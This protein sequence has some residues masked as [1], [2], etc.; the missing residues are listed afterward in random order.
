LNQRL[1]KEGLGIADLPDPEES[2]EFSTVLIELG[3]SN[4][5]ERM[6]IRKHVKEY[7]RGLTKPKRQSSRRWTEE[8]SPPEEIVDDP[9]DWE[10]LW[11]DGGSTKVGARS[12]IQ[13]MPEGGRGSIMSGDGGS[14]MATPRLNSRRCS[15]DS[16][17]VLKPEGLSS[18]RSSLNGRDATF[19]Q[20]DLPI[21]GAS[22]GGPRLIAA[23]L[24]SSGQ[25]SV[26][27]GGAGPLPKPSPVK[28]L[29]LPL[30]L[31]E[32]TAG[33]CS[34]TGQSP[35]K[36]SLPGQMGAFS[37]VATQ[38]SGPPGPLSARSTLIGCPPASRGSSPGSPHLT[39]SSSFSPTRPNRLACAPPPRCS[40]GGY[41]PFGAGT[42]AAYVPGPA[43]CGAT[44][45]VVQPQVVVVEKQWTP[46]MQS[47]QM[48]P[49]ETIVVVPSGQFTPRSACGAPVMATTRSMSLP[50]MVSVQSQPAAVLT[51]TAVQVVVTSPTRKYRQM[52]AVH[53]E[54][55][56]QQPQPPQR[57]TSSS[58][59]MVSSPSRLL[60]PQQTQPQPSSQ[61]ENSTL[62]PK[63]SASMTSTSP[64]EPKTPRSTLTSL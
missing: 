24:S 63:S 61:P 53:P 10:S 40:A 14:N 45:P 36:Q 57:S 46:R 8:E 48:T 25:G 39:L 62:S 22:T 1:R 28:S 27:R 3:F 31:R 42:Q 5:L 59:N 35:S 37:P 60:S 20:D 19:C 52:V 13:D 9:D 51:P 34:P 16:K 41:S 2:G 11:G 50:R 18:A 7:F 43:A 56:Q 6:V 54:S 38:R 21:N 47:R 64:M 17:P 58:T 30:N 15:T 33:P 44:P 29:R 12:D 32:D 26:S 4:A 23:S 55:E 49:R